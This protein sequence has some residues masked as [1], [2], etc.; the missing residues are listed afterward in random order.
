MFAKWSV[1][2]ALIHWGQIID[3]N[4]GPMNLHDEVTSVSPLKIWMTITTAS[5]VFPFVLFYSF[6]LRV[7]VIRS[8]MYGQ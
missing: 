7:V 5:R 4:V 8:A 6:A 1:L 3:S 2:S